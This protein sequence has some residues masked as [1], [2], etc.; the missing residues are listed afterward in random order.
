MLAELT[1]AEVVHH[2]R[3]YLSSSIPKTKLGARTQ[4]ALAQEHWDYVVQQ[5]MSHGPVSSSERFWFSVERL[6]AIIRENGAVPALYAARGYQRGSAALAAKGWDYD[7]VACGLAD[8]Y[9]KAAENNHALLAEV[10]GGFTNCPI[11][12]TF[13]LQPTV[14]IQ[15]NR[16][17]VWRRRSSRR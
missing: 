16:A 14:S 3:G 5:E 2:T 4:A 1:G 12:R 9:C 6:C 15:T 7:D 17:H 10:G 11:R 13:M 8:A